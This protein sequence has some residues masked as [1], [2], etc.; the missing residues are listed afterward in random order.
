MFDGHHLCS[1]RQE[2]SSAKIFFK[3]LFLYSMLLICEETMVVNYLDELLFSGFMGLD[4]EDA[5][6]YFLP[7][8]AVATVCGMM[9]GLERYSKDRPVGIKTCV[10]VCVGSALFTGLSS[11]MSQHFRDYALSH[12]LNYPLFSDPARVIGQLVTGVG[13]IGAGVI[14]REQNR[15][16][17]ITTAALVWTVCA[18][19]AIIGMGGYLISFVLSAGMIAALGLMEKLEIFMLRRKRKKHQQGSGVASASGARAGEGAQQAPGSSS[20]RPIIDD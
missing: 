7:R 20:D 10:L 5:L 13:F 4:S 8:A 12:G 16:S 1:L 18:I 6:L 15:I 3:G 9:V 19:G 2:S 14:F 11:L 17:G